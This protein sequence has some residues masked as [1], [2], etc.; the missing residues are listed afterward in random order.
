MQLRRSLSLSLSFL[1]FHFNYVLRAVLS[2]AT[3]IAVMYSVP[4][5]RRIAQVRTPNRDR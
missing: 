5:G 2:S 4:A 3:L 1:R